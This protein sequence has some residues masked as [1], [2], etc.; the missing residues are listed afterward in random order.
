VRLFIN[1]DGNITNLDVKRSTDSRLYVTLEVYTFSNVRFLSQTFL[2]TV[3]I[4][5]NDLPYTSKFLYFRLYDK[6]FICIYSLFSSLNGIRNFIGSPCYLHVCL[7]RGVFIQFQLLK[8]LA[9]SHENWH[10]V[11]SYW[12]LPLHN[13][14][15]FLHSIITAWR[16]SEQVRWTLWSCENSLYDRSD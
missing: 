5:L 7:S 11:F 6:T 4:C 16:T 3:T 10:T 2:T 1:Y 14:F 15:N 9:G 13:I 12:S 8:Y